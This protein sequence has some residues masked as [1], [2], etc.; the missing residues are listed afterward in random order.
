MHSRSF[1]SLTLSRT[2]LCTSRCWGSGP[3]SVSVKSA[4][5]TINGHRRFLILPTAKEGVEA[6][7]VFCTAVHRQSRPHAADNPQK[8]HDWPGLQ[9]WRESGVDSRRHWGDTGPTSVVC[10]CKACRAYV[11]YYTTLY[12]ACEWV[13]GILR[14]RGQGI[15]FGHIRNQGIES[16][17]SQ[18]GRG[19]WCKSSSQSCQEHLCSSLQ[20]TLFCTGFGDS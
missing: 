16:N 3:S 13:A 12:R 9:L 6:S 5:G 7:R 2:K 15:F 19:H 11:C 17:V 20:V 10:E 8:H 18:G 14:G 1:R 4:S